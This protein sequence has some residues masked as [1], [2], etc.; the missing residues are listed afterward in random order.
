[1]ARKREPNLEFI[2]NDELINELRKRFDY[3]LIVGC[4]KRTNQRDD[5][6]M[7]FVGTYH[8]ILGLCELGRLA[9]EAGGDD[10]KDYFIS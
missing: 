1:M 6:L 2:T 4:V 5:Y 8:G 9:A 3:L 10:G 7:S